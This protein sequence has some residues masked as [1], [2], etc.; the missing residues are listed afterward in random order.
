VRV[1]VTYPYRPFFPLLFGTTIN[2][3]SQTQMTLE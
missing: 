2:L 1:S 3:T